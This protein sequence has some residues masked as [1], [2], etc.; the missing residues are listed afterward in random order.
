M[1]KTIA[2]KNSPVIAMGL[3]TIFSVF[4]MFGVGSILQLL[5]VKMWYDHIKVLICFLFKQ[6]HSHCV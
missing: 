4:F 3:T 5:P 2:I 6:I 1:P